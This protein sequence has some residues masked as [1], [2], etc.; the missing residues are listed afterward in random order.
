MKTKEIILLIF[1]ILAGVI[2]YHAYTGKINVDFDWGE[3]F[4]F[5]YDEFVYEDSQQITPPFPPEIQVINA[6]GDVVVQGTDEEKITVSFQKKIWR[7]KEE[8]AEK[9]SK[10]LRMLVE[11]DEQTLM[12]STNR[13]EF[14]RKHF[15]THFKISV[16]AGMKAKIKSSYGRVKVFGV[17]KTDIDNRHGDVIALD[18][19]GDL[20]IENSYED[21][22]VENVQ[23]SCHIES[24]HSDVTVNNVK[25]MTKIIN[26]YG[27]IHAENISQEI[28]IECPHTSVSGQNLNGPVEIDSSYEKIVLHDADS[29]IIRGNHSPVEVSG[30]KGYVNI[31]DSY[32]RVDL[33]NIQGNIKID[34][35]KLTVDGR[36]IIGDEISI[37]SSYE[38]I[39]L[40]EFSGKTSIS[41]S[42][43]KL[44]LSPSPLTHPIE[45]KSQYTDIVLYWP[46][47]EKYPVE[48]QVKGGD[49]QW[50]LP[51]DL[52]FQE[53]NS[54]S[55]IKAFVQEIGKSSIF[56]SSTYGT[57]RI[58][59]QLRK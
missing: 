28:T 29:V 35:R 37:S 6:H 55:I 50:N 9:V 18:I 44:Q 25:G 52:S 46:P 20:R 16:P 13:D 42:H 45:V 41:L 54:M 14:K 5:T 11:K 12:I 2:F 21:V 8:Q 57:I 59:E 47:G 40:T 26:S 4:F 22:E 49:I 43:G 38:D 51:F 32:S 7:R 36:S 24:R 53:E 3:G 33:N 58:E 15:E 17:G 48:A 39:D 10:D 27:T 31:T 30:A 56:L 1:I 34:G 23:A 19:R